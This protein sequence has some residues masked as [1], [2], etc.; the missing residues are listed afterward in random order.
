MNRIGGASDGATF[1]KTGD[2]NL[3][4]SILFRPSPQD[5]P[6][7]PGNPQSGMTPF[8]PINGPW[9][10]DTDGDGIPDAVWIDLGMPVRSTPDGRQYKPMFAIYCV[11][12]DGRLN[13]NAHGT[14]AQTFQNYYQQTQ[15][16]QELPTPLSNTARFADNGAGVATAVL[17]RGQGM[18]PA[19]VNL[20]PLFQGVTG[21]Q[22]TAM[23][24]TLLGGDKTQLDGRYGDF[25]LASAGQMPRPG[26]PATDSRMV[27][28]TC[29]N[30]LH[31][32]RWAE[33]TGNYWG[34]VYRRHDV[35]DSTP[36]RRRPTCGRPG[37][38]GSTWAAGRCGVGWP[39]RP[40]SMRTSGEL[41]AK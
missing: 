12:M 28:R 5:H 34:F 40:I 11:D 24:Q 10:V 16:A 21:M 2:P 27:R 22:P 25:Q 38:S 14:W 41:D 8:D 39:I 29:S 19:D 26:F 4:R 33:Y 3:I 13:L 23:Y 30:P 32:N 1:I 36:T 6:F 18:G 15:T 31:Y 20:L 17:P 7:F 9:D 35:S 37:R